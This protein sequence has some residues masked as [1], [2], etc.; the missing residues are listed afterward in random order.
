MSIVD[1]IERVSSEEA[2][3]YAR[4][5]IKEE[6]IPVG[7]SSGA[8]LAAAIRVASR[9]EN[10]GKLIVAMIPSYTERYLST[11]LAEQERKEAAQLP[12]EPV[13]AEYLAKVT[14]H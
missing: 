12:V 2:L 11:L 4:R 10:K 7:I 1:E 9:G 14:T 6:G 8:A 5:L 13:S 3:S